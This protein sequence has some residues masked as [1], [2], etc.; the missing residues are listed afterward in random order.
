MII[1]EA[2]S[3]DVEEIKKI[4]KQT[5]LETF[6]NQNAKED[7]VKYLNN[8]F[9]NKKVIDEIVNPDTIFFLFKLKNKTIGYLKIN[10]GDAQTEINDNRSLEVERIYVLKEF[11]GQNIGQQIFNTALDFA[12]KMNLDYIWLGVWERNERAINFYKKNG[13]IEF[14][15][16]IF[17]LGNDKQR[18]ILMKK[19]IKRRKY[20]NNLGD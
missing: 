3:K 16:H 11:H 15:E 6:G 20:P 13:F 8:S 17:E 1:E 14:G 10:I 12:K 5:F 2:T 7:M 19:N 9:S 4:G 18:D